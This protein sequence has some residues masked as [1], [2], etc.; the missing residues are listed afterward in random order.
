MISWVFKLSHYESEKEHLGAEMGFHSLMNECLWNP[1]V[2]W[3]LPFCLVFFKPIFCLSSATL[4]QQ[5]AES[6]SAEPSSC[7]LTALPL[8]SLYNNTFGKNK[9]FS[10]PSSPLAQICS[11]LH[12]EPKFVPAGEKDHVGTET[13]CWDT[14]GLS[15]V[16]GDSNRGWSV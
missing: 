10:P 16:P 11:V 15:P 6:V 5:K 7:L 1:F 3:G 8:L 2:L 4:S 14:F 13:G 9:V 12:P